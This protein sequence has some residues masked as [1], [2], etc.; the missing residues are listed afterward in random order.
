[1]KLT[2]KHRTRYDYGS[3]VLL[4][5]NVVRLRPRDEP[6]QR[7]LSH[8]L[9]IEPRETTVQT[10]RD[11]FG[12][13]VA[14][15]T[16]AEPHRQMIVTAQSTVELSPR[17][18]ATA[19]PSLPWEAVRDRLRAE[20][21]PQAIER[22]AFVYDSPRV[23]IS[24]ELRTYAEGSLTPGRPIVEGVTA[25][26]RRMHR[27]F[28]YDKRATTVTTPVDEVFRLRRGVCQDLAQVQIGCLRALGLAARYVSGYLRTRPVAGQARLIGADASHAWVSVYCGELGWVDL[29]PTNDVLPSLDH[30]TVGWGRDYGDVAPIT[31]IY[32]GGDHQTLDVAVDVA[33]AGEEARAGQGTLR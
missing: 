18:A 28:V 25:L 14:Y 21:D 9:S 17:G 7:C 31:G 27:E 5:H 1:M 23:A 2:V 13:T 4:C 20:R 19:G 16:V 22:L 15:F 32:V 26:T 12:N 6:H 10:R 3:P 11:F 30:V 33:A 29:D 24:A 8:S